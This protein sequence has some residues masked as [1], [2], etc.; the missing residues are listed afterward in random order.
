MPAHT[1]L[2]SR[3]PTAGRA[4]PRLRPAAAALLLAVGGVQFSPAH[5]QASDPFLGQ[6]AL[7]GF[8]FCPRGWT[9]ANGQLMSIAQNTALFSLLGTNFGGNGQTTFG[10]PDLRG[11]T[12]IGQGQGPGLTNVTMGEVAGQESVT[13]LQTQMPQHTHALQASTQAATYAAPTG[14]RVLATTQNAGSYVETA[15]NTALAPTSVGL[16]GGNQPFSVRDPYLVMNWCIA[17]EGVYPS[18]P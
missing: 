18:R 14:N 7:F 13:L 4:G 5:A 8:N 9:A 16:S 17:T 3:A 2:S 12:P 11:R 1:D 15:P 6:M 10:L